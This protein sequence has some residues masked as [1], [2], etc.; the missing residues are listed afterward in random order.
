MG[1]AKK[2]WNVP[3]PEYSNNL[4]KHPRE[5]SILYNDEDND[6]DMKSLKRKWEHR[7]QG[8]LR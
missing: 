8:V 2:L 4:R 7:G 3:L 1:A 6:E 5:T